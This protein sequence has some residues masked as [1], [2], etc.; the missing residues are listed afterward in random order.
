[1]VAAYRN[2]V[3][4][5]SIIGGDENI[6]VDYDPEEHGYPAIPKHRQTFG[7]TWADYGAW[8]CAAF[9]IT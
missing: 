6:L 7:V 4:S 3:V 9:S 8:L 5:L 2:G 1:M